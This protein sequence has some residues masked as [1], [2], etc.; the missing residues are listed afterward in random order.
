MNDIT[1]R[2]DTVRDIVLTAI[3][4]ERLYHARKSVT[5]ISICLN[6]LNL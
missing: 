5:A 3:N 4:N 2:E 1:E 6:W